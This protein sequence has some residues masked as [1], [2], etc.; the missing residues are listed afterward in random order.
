MNKA[1]KKPYKHKPKYKRVIYCCSSGTFPTDL[2]NMYQ[3]LKYNRYKG[4]CNSRVPAV[5][6]LN[7]SG[8]TSI[9]VLLSGLLANKG[10]K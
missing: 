5:E 8:L 7:D 6:L 10:V 4:R 1:N 9:N 2:L 3:F